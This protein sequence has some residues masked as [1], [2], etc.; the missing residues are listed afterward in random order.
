MRK[1]EIDLSTLF[2]EKDKN[3]MLITYLAFAGGVFIPLLPIVGVILAY[4]KRNEVWGSVYYAHL[5]YLIR[6]FWGFVA[7]VVLGSILLIIAVGKLILLA[8]WIWFLFRII[9]GFI[10]LL[11]RQTVTTTGWFIK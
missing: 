4:V 5:T 10:K 11:D 9:Y 7:G 2:P 1:N 6:T 3:Y 8:V